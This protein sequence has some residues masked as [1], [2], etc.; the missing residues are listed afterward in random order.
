M[1]N[2]RRVEQ[3]VILAAGRGSR[4]SP[5]T[6]DTPKALVPFLGRPLIDFAAAH[7]VAA[8]VRRVAVNA[9]H[10][11]EGVAGHVYDRLADR[12]PDV[13]WHVSVEVDLLG[14]GG[15]LAQLRSWLGSEDFFVVNADAVFEA[16]LRALI[17]RRD[18]TGA[19]AV[20]MV[21]REPR[22]APLRV[23]AI[24]PSGDLSGLTAAATDAGA[25]FCG[26]HL[27]SSGLLAT[28]PDGAS[29]VVRE[30]YLPWMTA[31]ARVATW[32]TQGFWADT[33]T[34]ERY[35]D[36]HRRGLACLEKWRALGLFGP[37]A[38][39]RGGRG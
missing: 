23:V 14:T 22:Y 12:Y 20:W 36:A 25:T 39:S 19:D 2:H 17:Q 10:L 28:L 26:V 27:A 8:G 21:T 15:A 31:G 34:P 6:D 29:C 13:D 30:G 35:T 5:I 18:A 1:A 4:L 33:G 11:G 3:A 38:L 7:L 16:D 32:E 24:D 37:G 9:H